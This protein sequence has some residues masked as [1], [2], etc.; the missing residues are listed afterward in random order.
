VRQRFTDSG[1]GQLEV[2]LAPVSLP[3]VVAGASGGG[4]VRVAVPPGGGRLVRD[5]PVPGAADGTVYLI[6]DLGVRYPLPSKEVVSKLGYGSVI[7]LPVP[8]LLLGLVPAGP[9]LD[10]AAAAGVS[11]VPTTT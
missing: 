6:T 3:A 7:P 11:T 10:P 1:P 8:S 4:G 9:V 2:V 5:L